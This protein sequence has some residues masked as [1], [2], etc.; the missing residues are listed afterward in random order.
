[1]DSKV[2]GLLSNA[3]DHFS[4]LIRTVLNL[5]ST[6]DLIEESSH[7][8][9]F[10]TVTAICVKDKS[11]MQGKKLS[12]RRKINSHC[13]HKIFWN[14]LVFSNQT[15][16]IIEELSNQIKEIIASIPNKASR[17]NVIS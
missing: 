13:Y 14:S 12:F 11:A 10:G 3:K 16:G 5:L 6:T 15:K 17:L 7:L 9:P 1:M 4:A 2:I 8:R